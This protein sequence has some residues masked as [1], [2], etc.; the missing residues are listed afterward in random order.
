[1][2]ILEKTI[3]PSKCFLLPQAT[4]ASVASLYLGY[5]MFAAKLSQCIVMGPDFRHNWEDFG[6][7]IAVIWKAAAAKASHYLWDALLHKNTTV[8][9]VPDFTN[10]YRDLKLFRCKH[11]NNVLLHVCSIRMRA[12]VQSSLTG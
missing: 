8:D 11:V 3:S 2:Q 6:A 7:S 12:E 1:M 4:N 10:D 9:F 5:V